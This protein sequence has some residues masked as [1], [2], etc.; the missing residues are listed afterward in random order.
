[1][2]D[3]EI[4]SPKEGEKWYKSPGIIFPAVVAILVVVIGNLLGVYFDVI[5]T[6]SGFVICVEPL[7]PLKENTMS[8]PTVPSRTIINNTIYI[9]DLH[10]SIHPY[11]YQIFLNSTGTPEGAHINFKPDLIELPRDKTSSMIIDVD[12]DVEP[13]T[14]MVKI[15]AW[16]GDGTQRSC[17]YMLEIENKSTYKPGYQP[18]EPVVVGS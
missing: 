14:Y 10:Q 8:T 11:R 15:N 2:T 18:Q 16:G 5:N 12:P 4:S 13:G 7:K 6:Q 17:Y 3:K 1:M 9:I